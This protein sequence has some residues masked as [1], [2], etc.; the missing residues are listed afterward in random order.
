[1]FT[2]EDIFCHY[3]VEYIIDLCAF[4]SVPLNNFYAES[5]SSLIVEQSSVSL[6]FNLRHVMG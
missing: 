2:L 1:M 6:T 5:T 3:Y 4:V